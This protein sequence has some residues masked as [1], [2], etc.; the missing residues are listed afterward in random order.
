MHVRPRL[1]SVTRIV[2]WGGAALQALDRSLNRSGHPL[3]VISLGARG[4]SYYEYL[5]KQWLLGGR[6]DDALLE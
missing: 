1:L 3:Q 5:L 6:K 2:P 4:D